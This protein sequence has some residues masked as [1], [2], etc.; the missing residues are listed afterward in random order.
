LSLSHGH[1]VVDRR[2]LRA[3]QFVLAPCHSLAESKVGRQ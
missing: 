1:P 3:E 2:T